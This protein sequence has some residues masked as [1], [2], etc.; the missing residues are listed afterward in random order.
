LT[1]VDRSRLFRI[2]KTVNWNLY[3]YPYQVKLMSNDS[4]KKTVPKDSV[5]AE[6][7]AR[8]KTAKKKT[9][10]KKATTKKAAV[11]KA[12][13]K[14]LAKPK[15]AVPKKATKK[16][17]RKAVQKA[18]KSAALNI[19][20][21]ERWKMVAVTAYHKA[22]KRNFAPGNDLQDWVEAEQEVD[23]LLQG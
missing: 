17:I 16:S 6:K 2:A 11:K 21:E 9:A 1:A 8:K 7:V 4:K 14:A 3:H 19:S 18:E 10:K 12:V 23:K 5:K 13:K 15:K 22:E 20:P